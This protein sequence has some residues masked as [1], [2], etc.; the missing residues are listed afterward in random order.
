MGVFL[1]VLPQQ[2]LAVVITIGGADDDMDVLPVGASIRKVLPHPDGSLVV[3]LDEDDRTLNSVVENGVI[4]G[5]TDPGETGFIEMFL[6]FA[7]A[8]F[9][10][11][12]FQVANIKPDQIEELSALALG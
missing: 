9:G 3:K 6:D 12:L 11:S 10:M 4:A 2:V 7:H 5:A 1:E 8:D